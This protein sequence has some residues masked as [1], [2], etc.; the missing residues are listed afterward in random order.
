MRKLFRMEGDLRIFLLL[1]LWATAILMLMSP[2]SPLHGDWNHWDSAWFFMGGKA[3]MNGLRPYVD[4]AD[5]KGPLLWLI[6]GIGY[7]LSPHSYFGVYVL[8]CLLYGGIFYYNFKTARLFL[9]DNRRSLMVAVL[10]AFPYYLFWFHYLVRAE[11]FA[12]LP[13]AASMYYLFH[14]L[15]NREEAP[16]TV[17]RTG[18]VL[19]ASFMA[20]ILIKYSIAAMQGSM[21]VAALWFYAREQRKFWEPVKWLSIGAV[22]VALPFLIYLLTMDSLT[23]FFQEYILNT[24]RTLDYSGGHKESYLQELNSSLTNPERFTLL[25]II[26]IGWKLLSTQ[27]TCYR[28]VPLLTGIAFY[29]VAT[30]HHIDYYDGACTIFAIYLLIGLLN[31]A[32]QP[33][34]T[35]HLVLALLAIISWGVFDNVRDGSDLRKVG[36]WIDEDVKDA[37]YKM[38]DIISEIHQPRIMYLFCGEVGLGLKADALPAGKYWTYQYG[39]T[40]QM[41][42]EHVELLKS[43]KADFIIVSNENTEGRIADFIKSLGYVNCYLDSHD[44]GHYGIVKMGVYRK[45]K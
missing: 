14:L 4:F 45:Q 17:R 15:Y 33:L 31:V 25:V 5:S 36:R 26:I 43:R 30:K 19:G 2:D 39:S 11:D 41:E 27:L 35:I 23:A 9:K 20:L 38:N 6:Y 44:S 34:R 40:P 3:M 29:C 8:T 28:Y 24:F 32:K 13:V 21:I 18:L 12:T 37:Y 22:A 7:L 10:M 1:T 16:Y 42:M